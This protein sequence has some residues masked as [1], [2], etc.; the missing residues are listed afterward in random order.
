MNASPAAGPSR[1]GHPWG[2]VW[3]TLADTQPGDEDHREQT[4]N[5]YLISHI[6]SIMEVMW[7]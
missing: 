2:C 3:S 4:G 7:L 1:G 5:R 6:N